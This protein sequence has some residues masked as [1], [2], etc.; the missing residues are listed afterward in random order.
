MKINYSGTDRVNISYF[1]IY[2]QIQNITGVK[3][4]GHQEGGYLD[5]IARIWGKILESF[6]YAVRLE[7]EYGNAFYTN[8]RS[9]GKKLI[10]ESQDDRVIQQA[11][12][13]FVNDLRNEVKPTL[14][15][16][17]PNPDLKL[18]ESARPYKEEIDN[19]YKCILRWETRITD[20]NAPVYMK[21]L[22]DLISNSPE[23]REKGI[24]TEEYL[25]QDKTLGEAAQALTDKKDLT[26]KDVKDFI[27]ELERTV[28]FEWQVRRY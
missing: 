14:S 22:N 4:Y 8:I 3:V 12:K 24:E 20:K 21:E 1:N 11:V 9:L 28:P 15:F 27:A 23:T 16:D 25:Y 17:I 6:D 26:A 10:P 18:V 13:T 5:S 19:I 7:D 2:G